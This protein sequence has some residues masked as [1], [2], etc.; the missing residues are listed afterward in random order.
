MSI[1]S[2]DPTRARRSQDVAFP[3]CLVDRLP[4]DA[5][6]ERLQRLLHPYRL[7]IQARS[8]RL[9]LV[10]EET[11]VNLAERMLAEMAESLPSAPRLDIAQ[12]DEIIIPVLQ[13]G[14]K[15]DLAFRLT[16]IPH[17]IRPMTLSQAAFMNSMLHGD[18]DLIFGVGPT[19]TG[20]THLA[21]AAGL[22]LL[23]EERVRRLVVTCPHVLFEGEVMTAPLRAEILNDGQLTPMEDEL[24]AL[25]GHDQT[26]RLIEQGKIE[27]APLGGLRGRTFNDSFIVV[28]EAQ[29]MTVKSM[30][31]AVTRLGQGSRMVVTGDP[32]QIDLHGDE[33]SGLTD[34]LER[35]SGTDLALVH[36]FERRE[37]V[38]NPLV[39][40]LEALYRPDE[41][42]RQRAAA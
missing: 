27:I 12:V 34:L 32:Q 14:L 37:I 22:S 11:A 41:P 16:G 2:P 9:R 26:R 30:R 10:G 7:Q 20:K 8:G 40:G 35:I 3:E 13:G 39:V 36:T 19:G 33:L 29:N 18:H 15:G 17:P 5:L 24:H 23:A 42:G 38:R 28:D 31:M 4:M 1:Q 21:L 25:I 6:I